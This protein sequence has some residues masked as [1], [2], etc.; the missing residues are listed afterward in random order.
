[1]KPKRQKCG[2]GVSKNKFAINTRVVYTIIVGRYLQKSKKRKCGKMERIFEIN[3]RLYF[4]KTI[5][6]VRN[7]IKKGNGFYGMIVGNNVAPYHF[8]AGWKLGID[9][10]FHSVEEMEQTVCSAE[11]YLPRELGNKVVFYQYCEV[12]R[13]PR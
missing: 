3:N 6:Q 13:K 1:M 8:H 2:L 12:T 7:T 10:I 11:Y 4:K 9:V 5:S